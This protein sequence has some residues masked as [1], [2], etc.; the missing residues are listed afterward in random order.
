VDDFGIDEGVT[1]LVDLAFWDA[2]LEEAVLAHI[3]AD[4]RSIVVRWECFKTILLAAV[5][6]RCDGGPVFSDCKY[7]PSARRPAAAPPAGLLPIRLTS[8]ATL[9]MHESS[10]VPPERHEPGWEL[11]FLL[12]AATNIVHVAAVN[13]STPFAAR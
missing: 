12:G 13:A 1:M 11:L 8:S 2:L 9:F 6:A 3:R 4:R 7:R 5:A 10:Q